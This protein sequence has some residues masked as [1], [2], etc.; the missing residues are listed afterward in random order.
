MNYYLKTPD[1]TRVYRVQYVQNAGGETVTY[2]VQAAFAVGST[3]MPSGSLITVVDGHVPLAEVLADLA[4]ANVV[5][6]TAEEY[7][8]AAKAMIDAVW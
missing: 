8:A 5:T 4:L 6:A 2:S 1:L 7:K 3:P